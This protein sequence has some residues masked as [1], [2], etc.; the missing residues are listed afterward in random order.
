M[1]IDSLIKVKKE[2]EL[3]VAAATEDLVKGLV[4]I[5]KKLEAANIS[6]FKFRTLEFERATNT[7]TPKWSVACLRRSPCS[8]ATVD[9]GSLILQTFI[10]VP[11]PQ[12]GSE[13]MP[14]SRDLWMRDFGEVYLE[15]VR[16]LLGGE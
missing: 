11:Q 2:D 15:E 12:G 16:E 10:A 8:S 9:L 1:L 7:S 5:F 3:R 13:M 6:R 14:F 4:T